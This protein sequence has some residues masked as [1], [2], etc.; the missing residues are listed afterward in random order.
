MIL[1]TTPTDDHTASLRLALIC[2]GFGCYFF[3]IQERSN[4]ESEPRRSLL[5]L[6]SRAALQSRKGER[7]IILLYISRRFITTRGRH[8]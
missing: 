5:E 1:T 3:L 8:E 6:P 4:Q 2:S 7:H